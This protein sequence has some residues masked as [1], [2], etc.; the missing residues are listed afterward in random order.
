M[1]APWLKVVRPALAPLLVV[2]VLVVGLIGA[3]GGSSGRDAP[4]RRGGGDAVAIK[5]FAF[6]PDPMH[7]KVGAK[8]TWTNQ[9][10]AAHTVKGDAG[11]FAESEDLHQGDTFSHVFDRAGSYEYFCGIHSYMHGTVVVDG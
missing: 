3:T 10:G 11:G 8:V 7:V 2:P 9:D 6:V 4:E 5:D 1:S